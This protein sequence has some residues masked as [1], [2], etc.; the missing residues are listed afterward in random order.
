MAD[1]NVLPAHCMLHTCFVILAIL[2]NACVIKSDVLLDNCRALCND[3]I[4]MRKKVNNNVVKCK[5][6]P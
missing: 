2:S 4:E 3:K 1:E 5:C 6:V